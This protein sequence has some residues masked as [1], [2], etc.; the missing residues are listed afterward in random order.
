YHSARV[1]WETVT[2]PKEEGGHRI[3]NLVWWNKACSIKLLWLLFFRAGSIWVAWFTENVL[4]GDL[5]NLWTLRE[6]QTHASAT[7]KILR[8]RDYVYNW[9]KIVP[10][11]GKKCRFWSDNWSPF[12]NLKKHFDL[13]LSTS[14]GIRAS[15]TLHDLYQQGH[16]TGCLSSS[17]GRH[18]S[19]SSG[20]NATIVFTDSSLGRPLLW[21]DMLTLS[22]GTVSLA[23]VKKTLA[24]PPQCYNFGL[25]ADRSPLRSRRLSVSQTL[26]N[27]FILGSIAI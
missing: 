9:I 25:I 7:R 5:S 19:I 23:F 22:S 15:A 16:T 20:L 24:S 2:L 12:S 6:K 3:R 18:L 13:P 8:V 14:L 10:G 4:S 21:K 1:S 11:N 27:F 17:H 26:I